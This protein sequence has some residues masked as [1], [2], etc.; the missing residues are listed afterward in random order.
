M[1]RPYF[2]L[3]AT[4]FLLAYCA[5]GPAEAQL[6]ATEFAEKIKQ[7]PDAVLLDVR[8]P[9]E[10]AKGHLVNALNYNWQGED[11]SQQISQL[12]STKTV[13]IYCLS[14]SRSA[15]AAQKMRK[16]G[17]KVYELQGGI[18]KWRGA[19]LPETTDAAAISPGMTR[20][21]FNEL[22]NT[23]KIVLI[24]FYADWCAPCK[25]MKPY[26]D[27]ISRDMAAQVI[28]VRIN[29]DDNQALCK[30]LQIDALPVLQIYKNKGVVWRNEGFIG[31]EDVV[32]ELKKVEEG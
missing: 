11:F 9:E 30:E 24:D 7:T 22:F 12:D 32:R 31:K 14:G 13:C 2:L 23:D 19:N 4:V 26:L 8:T 1:L 10:F 3:L 28:V 6:S 16:Q 20:Q 27:E 29:A 25:R 15:A 5:Q 21:Q 18:M 17:F